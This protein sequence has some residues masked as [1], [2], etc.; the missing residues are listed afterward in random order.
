MLVAGKLGLQTPE[1]AVGS[2]IAISGGLCSHSL[3]ALTGLLDWLDIPRGTP[4][5][6]SQPSTC[7][8]C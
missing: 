1:M 8:P 2:L 3:T 6:R 7:S 4:A 5:R